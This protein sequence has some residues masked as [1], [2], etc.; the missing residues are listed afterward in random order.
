MHQCYTIVIEMKKMR[1]LKLM[2][3]ILFLDKI[4]SRDVKVTN[5]QKHP[6]Q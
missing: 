3:A 2:F 4:F 5:I 6:S 1:G